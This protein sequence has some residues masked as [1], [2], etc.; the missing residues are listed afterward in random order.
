MS[1][2]LEFSIFPMDQG[3][4]VSP[5]V[6]AVVQMIRDSGYPYRLTAMGTI[7][8]TE[9]VADAL[10]LVE[11]AHAL[12]EAKGCRRVYANVKLD[13]RQGPM[14]RLEGKLKS[15]NAKLSG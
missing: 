14:G 3:E 12:L 7:V 5:Y 4:S 1:V 8:E 15:V 2:L 9:N 10:A 6:A 13:S 11:R